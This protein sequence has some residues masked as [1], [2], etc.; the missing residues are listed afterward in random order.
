MDDQHSPWQAAT[1][2]SWSPFNWLS[3]EAPQNDSADWTLN[4]RA[5][6]AVQW[7]G[8]RLYTLGAAP[9]AAAVGDVYNPGLT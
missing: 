4:G 6:A 8:K 5:V 2:V 1:E 7:V 9:H 3:G